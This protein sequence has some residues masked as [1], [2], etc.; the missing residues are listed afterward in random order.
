MLGI[1]YKKDV[2]DVRESPSLFIFERLKHAGAQVD[3]HDAC[4]P[5]IP[6]TREHGELAGQRSVTLTPAVLASYDAVLIAT[7][8]RADS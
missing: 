2:E 1:A 8:H 3:Y 7:D 6:L 5:E 4:V